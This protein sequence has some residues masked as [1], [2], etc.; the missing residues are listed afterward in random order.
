MDRAV[1][2]RTVIVPAPG[3]MMITGSVAVGKGYVRR[4][5]HGRQGTGTEPVERM[6][7]QPSDE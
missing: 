7:T 2:E 1:L 5:C 4:R 6:E 3:T